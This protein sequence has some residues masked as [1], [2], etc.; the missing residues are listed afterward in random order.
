MAERFRIT[1]KGHAFLE[2]SYD[3]SSAT[4][5]LMVLETGSGS[6]GVDDIA[7]STRLSKKKVEKL[8]PSLVAKKLVQS[9]SRDSEA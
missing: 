3:D 8:M 9:V 6:S 1:K 5:I 7:E 2:N 4:S